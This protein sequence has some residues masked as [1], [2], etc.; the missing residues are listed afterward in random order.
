M[1]T[2]ALMN[3]S[4]TTMASITGA[5]LLTGI[6][7]IVHQ[8]KDTII[9]A[10]NAGRDIIAISMATITTGVMWITRTIGDI[11]VLMVKVSI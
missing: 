3:V 8:K 6:G 5:T 9:L 1:A 11:A 7:I 2:I 4:T 10:K